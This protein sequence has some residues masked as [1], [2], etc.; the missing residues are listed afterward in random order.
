MLD[1]LVKSNNEIKTILDRAYPEPAT[2]LGH[3]IYIKI[4]S[5]LKYLGIPALVMAALVPIYDFGKGIRNNFSNDLIIETYTRY[6]VELLRNG[7][8][9]RAEKVLK[10]LNDTNKLLPRVHY[11]KA[12]VSVKQAILK[13]KN[14]DETEDIINVLL[15]LNSKSN[16]LTGMYGDENDFF[17]LNLMQVEINIARADYKNALEILKELEVYKDIPSELK[18]ELHLKKGTAHVW[19]SEFREAENSLLK[20]SSILPKKDEFDELSAEIAFQKAK[21]DQFQGKYDEAISGYVRSESMFKDIGYIRGRIKALNNL[22]MIYSLRLYKGRDLNRSHHYFLKSLDLAKEVKGEVAVARAHL[23]IAQLK[24]KQGNL[25]ES[26]QGYILAL[27]FFKSAKNDYGMSISHS[28]LG[29]IYDLTGNREKYYFHAMK[30]FNGFVSLKYIGD[31]GKHAGHVA[32]AAKALGN[33]KDFVIYDYLSFVYRRY[34][35]DPRW[36]NNLNILK[37][38]EEKLGKDLVYSYINEAK[39][40]ATDLNLQL[41]ITGVDLRIPVQQGSAIN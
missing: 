16:F 8:P 13:A 3:S 31:I 40:I 4:Q 1:E 11:A 10:S 24:H 30:A 38:Q 15:I 2:G 33:D 25:Q 22:G 7:K 35:N 17:R 41:R 36:E 12:K 39:N 14:I 27:E 21:N 29:M 34:V 5:L 26:L 20:A 18:A 32:D 28:G 37:S 23:N 6:S 9:D 19:R